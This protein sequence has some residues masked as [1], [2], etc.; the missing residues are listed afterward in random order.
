MYPELLWDLVRKVNSFSSSTCLVAA[1]NLLACLD[2]VDAVGKVLPVVLLHRRVLGVLPQFPHT[3][4]PLYSGASTSRMALAPSPP[5]SHCF[6]RLARYLPLGALRDAAQAVVAERVG[7][8]PN[9]FLTGVLL[10]LLI[11]VREAVRH[12]LGFVSVALPILVIVRPCSSCCLAR[13]PCP[14]GGI[15]RPRPVS[16]SPIVTPDWPMRCR[17]P[18]YDLHI[19]HGGV[20]SGSLSEN[21]RGPADTQTCA[22]MAMPCCLTFKIYSLQTASKSQESNNV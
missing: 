14:D 1:Q 20:V 17:L 13:G 11:Q 4:G 2:P 8:F 9:S 18:V 21:S 6:R 19:L 22:K 10:P 5:F 3:L 15:V 16:C 12:V 7:D